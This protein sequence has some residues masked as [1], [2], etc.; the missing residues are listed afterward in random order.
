[1]VDVYDYVYGVVVKLGENLNFK[2][3][4][5]NFKI[6]NVFEISS[7]SNLEKKYI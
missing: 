4:I 6:V 7:K 1:V 5:Q 2:N 3:N